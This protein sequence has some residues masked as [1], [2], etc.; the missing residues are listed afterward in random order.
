LVTEKGRKQLIRTKLRENRQG[1]ST[2]KKNAAYRDWRKFVSYTSEGK[3]GKVY[4]RKTG[5]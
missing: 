4:R 2:A 5:N 1:S 3:G